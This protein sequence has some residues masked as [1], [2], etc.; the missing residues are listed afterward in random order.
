[1]NANIENQISWCRWAV[2]L[3]TGCTHATYKDGSEREACQHCYAECLSKRN[4]TAFGQWGDD[5]QR[6][7]T[8]AAT[9]GIFTK[10]ARFESE[11][12]ET[13]TKPPLV[14]LND[15]SDFCD[16]K[17]EL[18]QVR[19]RAFAELRHYRN[20]RFLVLTKRL[21]LLLQHADEWLQRC[22]WPVNFWLGTTIETQEAFDEG[23]PTLQHLKV[24]LNIPKVFF[25]MEPVFER[26]NIKPALTGD[27]RVDWVLIGGESGNNA[28][29]TN[30]N[31]LAVLAQQ[32]LYAPRLPRPAL[33]VKQL[34]S[35][36]TF[37]GRYIKALADKGSNFED[38]L[39]VLKYREFPEL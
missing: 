27:V 24:W 32:V 30:I 13:Y 19:Q 17:P 28:R 20:L 35:R 7:I 25:S 3:W 5:Q 11:K 2:N 39:E 37:D 26:I 23:W 8:K 4:T 29:V 14:F 22:P 12:G 31:H 38:Y 1:M 15:C 16:D 33:H 6:K 9:N 34:G 21:P 36:V 10:L 18:E